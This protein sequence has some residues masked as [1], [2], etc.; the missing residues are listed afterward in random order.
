MYRLG[1]TVQVICLR[2]DKKGSSKRE[3]EIDRQ[4]EIERETDT[5]TTWKGDGSNSKPMPKLFKDQTDT[6]G[7]MR[8]WKCKSYWN[9]E[10]QTGNEISLRVL[11]VEVPYQW[12]NPASEICSRISGGISPAS[13][14]CITIPFSRA[15]HTERASEQLW[16]DFTTVHVTV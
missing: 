3:W 2:T 5:Q 7:T 12:N 6:T 16:G 14:Y 15:C 8:E 10:I 9:R 4:T 11:A 1:E 13:L